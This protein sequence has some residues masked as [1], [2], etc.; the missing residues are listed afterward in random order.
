MSEAKGYISAKAG[1]V[2][3]TYAVPSDKGAKVT[4]LTVGGMQVTGT[5][6]GGW[7]EAYLAW[8]PLL[9]RDKAREE[10]LFQAK[11]AGRD[12]DVVNREFD[13]REKDQHGAS[14]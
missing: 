9:R 3:W 7:G 13:A 1:D 2:K 8:A 11:A 12:L 4:L 6:T 14:A 10:A 5:W